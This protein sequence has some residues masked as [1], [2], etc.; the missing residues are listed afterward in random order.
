MLEF[1]REK[2]MTSRI[3]EQE[4][5]MKV[6]YAYR[7]YEALNMEVNLLSLIQDIT[8]LETSLASN[9]DQ[10]EDVFEE[11]SLFIKEVILATLKHEEELIKL[12]SSRLIKWKINRLNKVTVAIL[13]FISA[14]ILYLNGPKAPLID[15]AVSLTKRYGEEK[16]Y[17][18]V[19][20][21]LDK[22]N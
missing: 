10:N 22:I 12:I 20:A 6:I 19:N 2:K 3:L 1:V 15:T 14:E 11:V 4:I 8:N 7:T 9:L 18:F 13:L 17:S 16:D 21:I 5:I